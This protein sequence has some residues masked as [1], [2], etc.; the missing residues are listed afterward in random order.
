M[1]KYEDAWQKKR[2]QLSCRFAHPLLY[3]IHKLVNQQGR[4]LSVSFHWSCCFCCF[5]K[6]QQR[7]SDWNPGRMKLLTKAR[8]HVRH[9]MYSLT[10]DPYTYICIYIRVHT[11]TKR[12]NWQMHVMKIS[13]IYN[14]MCQ[15]DFSGQWRAERGDKGGRRLRHNS[16]LV[17]LNATHLRATLRWAEGSTRDSDLLG[18]QRSLKPDT[19]YS[20]H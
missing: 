6:C 13:K 14:E 19:G 8:T 15:Q 5:T 9:S 2:A 1:A 16:V 12:R 11:H 18:C 3:R 20:N 10:P 7:L 4:S 17:H